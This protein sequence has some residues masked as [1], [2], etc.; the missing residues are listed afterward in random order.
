MLPTETDL[1]AWARLSLAHA[2]VEYVARDCGVDLL[3][4]KG[5]ATTDRFRLAGRT[6]SDVD[7]L[8]R[9]SHVLRLTTALEAADFEPRTGFESG[10]I[11]RHAANLHHRYWGWVDVHRSFPGFGVEA[12]VAFEELWR[13]RCTTSIAAY[14][15]QVPSVLDQALLILLHGARDTARGRAD[16][17][18]VRAA[19]SDAELV[20]VR[21]LANELGAEVALA[22]ASGEL[23]NFR[24][25]AE[26]DLWV[27]ASEGGTRLQE[28][29]ARFRAATSAREKARLCGEVLLVNRDHLRMRLGHEPSRAEVLRASGHRPVVAVRELSSIAVR[30]LPFGGRGRGRR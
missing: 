4:V 15:V 8:V 21:Q 19:L 1:P 27:V 30:R 28:W 14:D 20:E 7:V 24:D 29:R 16:I 3:H 18:R 26:H 22:A 13:R 25:R 17:D 12:A 11:F 10:S 9:P 23:A 6:S 2:V 5:P